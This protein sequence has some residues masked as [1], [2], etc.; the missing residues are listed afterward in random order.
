MVLM[1]HAFFSINDSDAVS[2]T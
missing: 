2:A 1:L